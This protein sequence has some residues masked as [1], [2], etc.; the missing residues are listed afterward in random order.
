MI[1]QIS[2]HSNRVVT[3]PCAI[4]LF[5]SQHRSQGVGKSYAN[6]LII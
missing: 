1:L 3:L 2:P 6:A 4:E 5:Q